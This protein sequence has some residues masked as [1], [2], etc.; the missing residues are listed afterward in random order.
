MPATSSSLT[1]VLQQVRRQRRWS[2]LEL[3]FRL[4]VSQRHVSFVESGRA[5]PSRGLLLAWLQALEA[6]LPLRNHALLQAGYAPAY[7]SAPIDD[8][9]LAE[10]NA[11][12]DHLLRAHD[13]M[14]ALVLDALWNVVRLNRGAQWLAGI[15]MPSIVAD[16]AAPLNLLDALAHPDGLTRLV[17]NLQDVGPAMLARLRQEAVVHPALTSKVEDFAATLRSRLGAQA[18]P[19]GGWSAPAAPVL[20]TRYA[21]AVGELAFF[22]MFTT[23]GTPQEITLASLRVEHLFAADAATR[24]V[25]ETHVR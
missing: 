3:S 5:R 1:T 22:G 7:G 25:L 11:A 8:P 13:P 16:A 6:P 17:V 20:T 4:G 14:P 24:T 12:L 21:T 9:V 18:T 15:L 10:A 19:H 2:Q 23:F